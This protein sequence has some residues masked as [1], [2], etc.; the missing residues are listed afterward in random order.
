MAVRLGRRTS[1]LGRH[2]PLCAPSHQCRGAG[3]WAIRAAPRGQGR[4]DSPILQQYIGSELEVSV[5][6][7]GAKVASRE[8]YTILTL[9]KYLETL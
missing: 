6:S 1:A 3:E 9:K 5:A 2:L 4:I 7:N 8:G